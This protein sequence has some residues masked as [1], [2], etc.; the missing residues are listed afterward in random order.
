MAA[1]SLSYVAEWESLERDEGASIYGFADVEAE[2]VP[3]VFG[4]RLLRSSSANQAPRILDPGEVQSRFRKHFDEWYSETEFVSSVAE[5]VMHPAFQRII[6]L[7]LQGI[8]LVL[9]QLMATGASEWF[10]ALS[11]IVGEDVAEGCDD[12]REAA[13]KWLSWGESMGYV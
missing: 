5:S 10:W 11:S 2:V 6:G 12:T 3:L 1:G 4:T 7:G 8:P 9:N 13:A